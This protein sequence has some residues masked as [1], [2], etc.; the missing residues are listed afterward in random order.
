MK[1]RIFN[2]YLQ[3]N[4]THI[5]QWLVL[6]KEI[7]NHIQQAYHHQFR[8]IVMG[9]FNVDVDNSHINRQYRALKLNFIYQLAALDL[10][11]NYNLVHKDT[12]SKIHTTWSHP[13]QDLHS[14][15]DYVWIS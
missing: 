14:R 6:E 4:N 3:A 13:M 8:I 10:Y 15:I 1:L 7:L 11:D 2:I 9:D 5:Q 12:F